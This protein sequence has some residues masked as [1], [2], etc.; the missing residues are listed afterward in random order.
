[1]FPFFPQV[2]RSWSLVFRSS[3]LFNNSLIRCKGRVVDRRHRT[4]RQRKD[5]E[6]CGSLRSNLS[7]MELSQG[8]VSVCNLERE[9][10]T[11]RPLRQWKKEAIVGD[12]RSRPLV[13]EKEEIKETRQRLPIPSLRSPGLFISSLTSLGTA[14]D[15]I[16][17]LTAHRPESFP[18]LLGSCKDTVV[19]A[20]GHQSMVNNTRILATSQQERLWHWRQ[21]LQYSLSGCAV[22]PRGRLCFLLLVSYCLPFRTLLSNLSFKCPEG[23]TE[24]KEK[25][26]NRSAAQMLVG[27][28]RRVPQKPKISESCF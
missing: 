20:T 15:M 22:R 19:K 2:I 17:T 14:K 28:T 21:T 4:E 8:C 1:M 23:K 9:V 16:E 26:T 18:S 24:P 12:Q 13:Q 5:Q 3:S 7:F 27:K 25:T 6:T 11:L 10:K